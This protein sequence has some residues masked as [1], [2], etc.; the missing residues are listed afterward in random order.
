MINKFYDKYREIIENRNMDGKN[1]G[2]R[3]AE[4]ENIFATQKYCFTLAA[5]N[6][7]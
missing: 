2:R 5:L 4:K 1:M 7:L 6:V 3:E